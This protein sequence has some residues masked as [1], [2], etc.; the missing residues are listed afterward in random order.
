MVAPSIHY[1]KEAGYW[2][3]RYA[4]MVRRHA[5]DWQAYVWFQMAL[6][7]YAVSAYSSSHVG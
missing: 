6:A 7:M 3:V 5:Q 2:E 4:G 1:V